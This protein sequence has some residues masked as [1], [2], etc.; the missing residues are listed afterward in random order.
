MTTPIEHDI[1]YQPV[2][3]IIVA[4]RCWNFRTRLELRVG[5]D[6]M[7]PHL[8]GC[9]QVVEMEAVVEEKVE[10]VMELANI[11]VTSLSDGAIFSQL[12]FLTANVS[13]YVASD[14]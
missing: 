14:V 13:Q 11:S 8:A 9:F 1:V 2:V 10:A 7:I 6:W 5:N 12:K 4:Y 3:P